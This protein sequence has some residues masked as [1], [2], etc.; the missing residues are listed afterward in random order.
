MRSSH[1][2]LPISKRVSA[3]LTRARQHRGIEQKWLAEKLGISNVHLCNLEKGKAK[4][5][6]EMLRD[7]CKAL[8]YTVRVDIRPT[9]KEVIRQLS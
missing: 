6:F 3:A 1:G 4:P 7:W 8:G 5:S 9:M 2:G